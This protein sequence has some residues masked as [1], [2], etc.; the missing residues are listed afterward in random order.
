MRKVD[1]WVTFDEALTLLGMF[2]CVA[3]LAVI[4]VLSY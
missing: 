1:P 2:S 4:L 3:V